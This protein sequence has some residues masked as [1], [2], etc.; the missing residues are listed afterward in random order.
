M[1]KKPP[2]EEMDPLV[3]DFSKTKGYGPVDDVNE[4]LTSDILS[5][6]HY[7]DVIGMFGGHRS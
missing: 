7:E 5:S 4:V 3:M 2:F 6:E 1:G